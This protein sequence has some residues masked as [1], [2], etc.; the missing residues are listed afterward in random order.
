[1]IQEAG[2]EEERA[3]MGPS[4]WSIFFLLACVIIFGVYRSV[5]PFAMSV[6]CRRDADNW[7]Y[8]GSSGAL[9]FRSL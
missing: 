5:K 3:S 9:L 1:M 8:S 4:L 6:W 2:A 7:P